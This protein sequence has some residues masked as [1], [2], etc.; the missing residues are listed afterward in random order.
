MHFSLSNYD[1]Q[2]NNLL[3]TTTQKAKRRA[4]VV[5]NALSQEISGIKSITTSCN[6]NGNNSP[7]LYMAK[8]MIAD[9][10]AESSGITTSI[11]N[12]VVKINANVNAIFFV[13]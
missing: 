9:T 13:E 6:V 10:A 4:D 5:A 7:R 8:N 11:S 12:G 3:K 1:T 2:C